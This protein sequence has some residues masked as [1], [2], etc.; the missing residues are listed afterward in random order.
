MSS[1]FQIVPLFFA[2]L[3]GFAGGML[4][5]QLVRPVQAASSGVVTARDFRLVDASGKLLAELAPVRHKTTTTEL[6]IYGANHYQTQLGTDGLY[7]GRGYGDEDLGVG[8]AYGTSRK[9]G[10]AIYFWYQKRG[11]M[12]LGLDADKGGSPSAWM[13]DEGGHTIWAAPTPAP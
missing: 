6:I 10:A 2:V 3:A 9:L 13:Y 11:R 5:Q 7:F 4:S 1:R 8:Y 12:G